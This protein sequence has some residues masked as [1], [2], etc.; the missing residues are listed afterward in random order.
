[1]TAALMPPSLPR[2]LVDDAQAFLSA[3][4]MVA[5]GLHLLASAELL[6]GGVPG[7]AFLLRYATHWPLGICLMLANVPFYVLAWRSLGWRFVGKTPGRHD[8]ARAAGRAGAAGPGRASIHPLLAALAGGLLVGV[9]LVILLRHRGRLGGLG[10][11]AGAAAA[12]PWLERR[13]DPAPVRRRHRCQRRL[14]GQQQAA[15]V[16]RRGRRGPEPRPLLE[17]PAAVRGLRTRDRGTR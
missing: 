17:S 10:I 9:G 7:L 14:A 13:R 2:V 8:A 4:L 16:L 5:V 12:S 1:M 6:V 15:G 3:T 11:V